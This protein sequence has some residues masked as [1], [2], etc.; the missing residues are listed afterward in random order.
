MWACAYADCSDELGI[1]DPDSCLHGWWHRID[2]TKTLGIGARYV[3]LFTLRS[4]D[5]VTISCTPRQL[6]HDGVVA[7]L[8][9]TNCATTCSTPGQESRSNT[10][11]TARVG[12]TVGRFHSRVHWLACG[13]R[14]G[15]YQGVCISTYRGTGAVCTKYVVRQVSDSCRGRFRI[16][17]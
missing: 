17:P 12:G 2:V 5:I 9:A 3:R 13:L 15:L 14:S 1:T 11:A 4:D 10:L 16:F 7:T 8:C 6:H